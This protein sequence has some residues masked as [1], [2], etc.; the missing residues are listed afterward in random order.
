[1]TKPGT[2]LIEKYVL[3]F[4]SSRMMQAPVADLSMEEIAEIVALT[5]SLKKAVENREP[6]LRAALLK[7]AERVGVKNE[8]GGYTAFVGGMEVRKS[9]RQA[10]EPDEDGLLALLKEKNIPT[11]EAFDEVKNLQLNPTKVE[12]L[13]QTGKLTQAEVDKLRKTSDALSVEPA[14]EMKQ[15]LLEALSPVMA[16]PPKNGKAKAKAKGKR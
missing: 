9:V 8:K 11:G 3:P 5:R 6:S 10:V 2:G 12:F 15:M 4:L 14:T 1:M 16:S 7:E 13:V